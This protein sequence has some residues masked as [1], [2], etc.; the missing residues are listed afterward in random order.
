MESPSSLQQLISRVDAICIE[1]KW[2]KDWLG[3]GCYLHLEVSEFIESLRG[4]GDS[5][6]ASEA[7]DVLFALLA[8]LS[9]HQI[10]VDTVL[11]ELELAIER[12]EKL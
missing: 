3:G 1:R 9:H 11:G 5:T 4:K 6:P 12:L 10:S 8:M 7:G 2:Q